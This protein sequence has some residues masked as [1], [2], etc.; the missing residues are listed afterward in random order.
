MSKIFTLPHMPITPGGQPHDFAQ[1]AADFP[2]MGIYTVETT[3]RY[4]PGTRHITWDGRVFKY[5]LGVG[6]VGGG[7]LAFFKGDVS[8][9]GVAYTT[10]C[11][12]KVAGDEQVSIDS[13]SFAEDIL[14]G[15]MILLYGSDYTYYQQRGIVGNNYC[16]STQLDIDLEGPLATAITEDSTGIEVMPNPYRYIGIQRE[17]DAMAGIPTTRVISGQYSWM[18]TWGMCNLEPG[19]SM[20]NAYERQLVSGNGAGAVYLHKLDVTTKS[21]QHVGFILDQGS[22]GVVPFVMLQ[23]SI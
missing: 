23:I 7:R 17:Y 19:E 5:F 15:G 8:T 6:T 10:V 4:I 18:Q 16:S 12:S 2:R 14:A 11:S 20:T 13:Q 9:Y 21:L 22:S 1:A 3:Q